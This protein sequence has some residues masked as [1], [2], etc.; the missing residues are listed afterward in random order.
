MKDLNYNEEMTKIYQ[1]IYDNQKDV[2]SNQS[3][4]RE[5]SNIILCEEKSTTNSLLEIGGGRGLDLLK[6]INICNKYS[7]FE[8]VFSND[9][10][11]IQRIYSTKVQWHQER[12][13][14]D[15]ICGKFDIILDNGCLHHELLDSYTKYFR[16]LA[17]LSHHQTNFYLNVYGNKLSENTSFMGKLPDGR[18]GRV[19]HL[20]DSE[21]FFNKFGWTIDK[22]WTLSN[23]KNA[24]PYLLFKLNKRDL[25]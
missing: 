1:N 6:L 20:N 15:G 2:W 11:E 12:F 19:F 25:L 22:Y 13:P 4:M 5:V 18:N 9:L 14:T 21:T 8:P 10:K 16:S 24:R 7:L 17:H 3:A 23:S